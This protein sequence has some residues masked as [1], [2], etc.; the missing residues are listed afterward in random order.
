MLMETRIEVN[1]DMKLVPMCDM[2]A[3]GA[4]TTES[5]CEIKRNTFE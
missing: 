4:E 1:D 5:S 3:N 2:E